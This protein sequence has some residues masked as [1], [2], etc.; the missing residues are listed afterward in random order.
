MNNSPWLR[1]G[2]APNSL[3]LRRS[4]TAFS[5]RAES[6][7]EQ[8]VRV[9]HRILTC[10]PVAALCIGFT[11]NLAADDHHRPGHY[12]QTNLVSD[13]PGLAAI[14]DSRLVNPWGLSASATSAWWVA[15]NG[16]GLS[17]LYNGAGAVQGLVVTVPNLPGVTDPS[18]P[19]G[20]VFNGVA[21]E[22]LVAA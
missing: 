18:A 14:T 11:A 4:P 1:F 8:T 16:T 9:R 5:S 3:N 21:T 13:V 12:Q 6:S 7:R 10:A 20:A 22:F 19:T 2:R 15:D 17:T